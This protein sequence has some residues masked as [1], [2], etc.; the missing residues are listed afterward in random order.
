MPG[1]TIWRAAPAL[2]TLPTSLNVPLPT[3]PLRSHWR[4]GT[5]ALWGTLLQPVETSGNSKPVVS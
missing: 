2:A 5:D 3:S 4:A 1:W